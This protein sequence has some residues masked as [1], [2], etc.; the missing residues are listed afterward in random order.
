MTLQEK[1]QKIKEKCKQAIANGMDR[2]EAVR[3]LNKEV[4]EA[5]LE[6]HQRLQDKKK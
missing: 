3:Q 4:D 1:V 5:V 6:E 2:L